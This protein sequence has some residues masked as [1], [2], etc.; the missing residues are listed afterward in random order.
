VNAFRS[1]ISRVIQQCDFY[2]LVKAEH[3]LADAKACHGMGRASGR[4]RNR[5]QYQMNM[6]VAAQNI[7]RLASF[8][9]RID[10]E[11][12]A[13]CLSTGFL[14]MGNAILMLFSGF[15]CPF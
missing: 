6:T 5:L 12:A 10:R 7:K 14:T 15:S 2:G 13:C 1:I 3:L 9:S 8:R 4:G 11:K